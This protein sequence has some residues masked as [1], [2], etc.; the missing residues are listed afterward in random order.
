MVFSKLRYCIYIWCTTYANDQSQDI[1]ITCIS[2]RDE[3]VFLIKSL[4]SIIK[5][6]FYYWRCFSMCRRRDIF[7]SAYPGKSLLYLHLSIFKW[8]VIDRF[9]ISAYRNILASWKNSWSLTSRQ[10]RLLYIS[11]DYII[12]SHK[13]IDIR[14]QFIYYEIKWTYLVYLVLISIHIQ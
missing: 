6:L 8:W 5:L 10:I 1:H 12:L 14:K 13:T 2:S 4:L 3:I 11:H 9:A 7:K